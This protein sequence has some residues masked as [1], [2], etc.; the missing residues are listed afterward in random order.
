MFDILD[1]EDEIDPTTG[2]RVSVHELKLENNPSE[3][4]DLYKV[5][6]VLNLKLI[7]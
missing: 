2:L 5:L 7:I 6:P 3:C 1:S 4:L